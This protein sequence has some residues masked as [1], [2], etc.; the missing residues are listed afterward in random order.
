MGVKLTKTQDKFLNGIASHV[1]T[2]A[3]TAV[4]AITAADRCGYTTR[5]GSTKSSFSSGV[6]WPARNRVS[7]GT[8]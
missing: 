8:D 5:F 3:T 4:A 7:W 6:H 2:A 1:L